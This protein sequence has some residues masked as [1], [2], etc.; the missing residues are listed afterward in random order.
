MAKKDGAGAGDGAKG[1]K[2]EGGGFLDWLGGLFTG[3][4][5]DKNPGSSGIDG[6]TGAAPQAPVSTAPD[7]GNEEI[8]WDK[9]LSSKSGS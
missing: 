7:S 1:E 8:D 9:L 6:V 3:D 4:G 2:D 5:G